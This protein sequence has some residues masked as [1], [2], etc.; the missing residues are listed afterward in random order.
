MTGPEATGPEATEPAEPTVE[1][2]TRLDSAAAA[3]VRAL[4]AAAT[5]ADGVSPL[6]EA[7]RLR[8]NEPGDGLVHVRATANGRLLGYGQLDLTDPDGPAA[9]AE[10]VVD[11]AA[12][13]AGVG[14]AVLARLRAEAGRREL[15]VWAHGSGVAAAALARRAGLAPV[16]E[17]LRMQR[18][19]TGLPPRPDPPAGTAIRTFVPGR[20]EQGWLA[21]N[22]AAF[23]GHPEQG[24]WTADD[25]AAREAEPW[26]DPAGFFLAVDAERS[27]TITGF[28]WTKLE[29]GERTGEVY[30]IGVHP[31]AQ[32]SGLG[33]VLLLTG[34]HHLADHGATAI[35]LYVEGDS[36]AVRLYQRTGFTVAAR[37][38]MYA[39]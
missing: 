24:R 9:D 21:V 28:H 29:R 34:L 32:G 16:R 31:D 30:V 5:E 2:T 22:A 26:F 36:P 35:E 37:D 15:R 12:R 18:P 33:R 25:L 39:G 19:A 6:N 11:P 13:R 17:L 14:T 8:L 23:A 7:T 4:A 38:I 10:L 1:A 3:Q 27:G 20:D